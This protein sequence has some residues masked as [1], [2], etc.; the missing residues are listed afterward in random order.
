MVYSVNPFLEMV[1]EMS[2]L[3][4]VAVN[5]A[6]Y[7]VGTGKA[8]CL[9]Y[10][11]WTN[12]LMRCYSKSYLDKHPSHKGCSVTKDWL[13]FSNF[14]NW[15]HEQDWQGKHLDKDILKV[16]NKIYTPEHCVFVRKELVSLLNDNTSIRG[17]HPRGVS[18][19]NHAQK[20][21]ATIK[22][23]G[24]KKHLGYFSTA[25]DASN[26]YIKAK[27]AHIRVIAESEPLGV[28]Q[29]LIAHAD[30]L[31]ERLLVKGVDN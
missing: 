20:F 24:K 10:R 9:Y 11:K 28:K 13:L 17:V 2:K 14:K 8:M 4:D 30:K 16:G 7:V 3:Y 22:R 6:D 1:H 25:A 29:G 27:V 5:D 12:M 23:H 18:W 15:V 31:N 21:Q 26:E 19:N